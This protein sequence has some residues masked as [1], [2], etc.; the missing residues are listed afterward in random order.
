MRIVSKYK[1]YYDGIQS[2]GMDSKLVYERFENL[3]G[4]VKFKNYEQFES[5]LWESYLTVQHINILDEKYKDYRIKTEF[6]L[7]GF[8]GKL[9][10][11]FSFLHINKEEEIKRV[12]TYSTDATLEYIQKIK[13]NFGKI[14]F[15]E[16]YYQ[17][18]NP[19]KDELDKYFSHI[20]YQQNYSQWFQEI[21]APIFMLTENPELRYDIEQRK[22][23]NKDDLIYFKKNPKLETY[24]FYKVKDSYS[25]FQDLSQFLGGILTKREKIESKLTDKEKVNQHGFD[26]KY[27]F[28][29]RPNKNK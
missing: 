22:W 2:F 20:V 9:F 26:L 24:Q 27:G 6:I 1:D 5:G 7:I 28:R 11:C 21:E 23:L 19:T 12:S 18:C 16:E 15:I 29:T 13:D 14:E 10:P 17:G 8:C 3:V 25:A 4:I